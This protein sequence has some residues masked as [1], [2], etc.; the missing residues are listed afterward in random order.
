MTRER[1]SLQSTTD[2]QVVAQ[3]PGRRL[4]E[5]QDSAEAVAGPRI[6]VA[7]GGTGTGHAGEQVADAPPH[8][9]AI[10]DFDALHDVRAVVDDGVDVG[11]LGDRPAKAR[12]SAIGSLVSSLKTWMLTITTSAPLALAVATSCAIAAGSSV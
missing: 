12:F 5:A 6:G 4:G 9:C 11:Q 7:V 8:G 10:H 1:C 3:T 2:D